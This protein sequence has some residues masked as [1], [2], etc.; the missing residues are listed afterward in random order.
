MS[1]GP[2][3]FRIIAAEEGLSLR[4][5]LP[6]RLD[7]L[8][9]QQ[10]GELVKAGG[11][12]LNN[13]RVRIPSVRVCEGERVTVYREALAVETL[14]PGALEIA[15][16]GRDYAVVMK[17]SGVP[18]AATKVSAR[19][20]VSQALIHMLTR[21]GVVRPYVG[22][23]HGL[24]RRASGLVLFTIRG[25][26]TRS[27]HAEFR[28]ASCRRTFY[29]RLEGEAPAQLELD[30]PAIV[31][32]TG[33]VR[34]AKTGSSGAP[35]RFRRLAV[36]SGPGDLV[37]SLMEVVLERGPSERIRLSAKALGFPVVTLRSEPTRALDPRHEGASEPSTTGIRGPYRGT[38]EGDVATALALHTSAL[39][40]T[41]PS[42]GARIQASTV[43]PAWAR[44]SDP[45]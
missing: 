37:S 11:V 16:R 25:Q 35:V 9:K 4:Q 12:Y 10:A 39:D 15:A 29:V 3:R 21:E 27:I 45:A 13:V 36:S 24:E 8:T 22:V 44:V 31:S 1:K 5:L 14:D 38:R 34:L 42:S 6:R 23:V 28:S 30:R 20:T 19:G 18:V 2:I 33:V 7:G 41:H 26:E 40:F 32:P 17:P 43:V